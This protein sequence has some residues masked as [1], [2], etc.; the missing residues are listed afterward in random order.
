MA[1]R[2]D[3]ELKSVWR[4]LSSAE[5]LEGW[6]MIALRQVGPCHLHAARRFPGNE[7]ALLAAFP[8]ARLPPSRQLPVGRGFEVTHVKMP[9]DAGD[10]VTIGLV[11]DPAGSLELFETMAED[12][13]RVL[14]RSS[15]MT[16]A[17]MMD[18]FLQ[19]VV[20][21][22]EFMKRPRDGL[23]SPEQEVGLVGEL[24][25]LDQIVGSGVTA[26][27]CVQSWEG[28]IDGVH[29][30]VLGPGAIEVKTSIAAA[31]FPAR[32]GSLEQLEDAFR[33][34][35][36]LASQ[37][38]AVVPEGETLPALVDRLRRLFA[39]AGGAELFDRRV[40]HA[41]YLDI[42]ADSYSRTFVCVQTRLMHVD[43]AFPKLT[44]A[45]VGP[46]IRRASY[47][48]DID[49]VAIAGVS[50]HDALSALEAI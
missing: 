25:T 2:S 32:I 7:E 37:R 50:L 19:R 35:L 4:A 39:E 24:L 9:G 45:I 46:A 6:R 1:L 15:R 18:Q 3:E 44:P 21:W 23:L 27:A 33:Q 31:G 30:F 41:G 22:Q 20:A 14:D 36:Y 49:L 10:A 8:G 48:I 26:Q 28:P 34:P 17:T 12:C 29:D 42:H 40:M 47:E 5:E 43:A 13:I 16:V 38:L 11:R